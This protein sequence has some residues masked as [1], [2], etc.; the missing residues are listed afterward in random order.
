[1][2]AAAMRTPV[3]AIAFAV[4]L[5]NSANPVILAMLVAA[6]AAMLTGRQLDKRSIYSARLPRIASTPRSSAATESPV[7][8]SEA[9]A[10]TP[11]RSGGHDVRPRGGAFRR[12][13][14]AQRRSGQEDGSPE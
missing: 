10:A 12:R 14:G 5:T 8:A 9:H 11:S 3:A 7:V 13:H 2:L 6:G 4:E 1:M